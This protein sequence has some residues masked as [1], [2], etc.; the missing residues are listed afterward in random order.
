MKNSILFT[1][2]TI[3][4]AACQKDKSGNTTL[5]APTPQIK[6]YSIGTSDVT[7]SYDTQGRLLTRISVIGN[8][9]YVYT[10]S[11]NSVKEDYYTGAI[12]TGTKNIDLNADGF[13]TKELRTFPATGNYQT[14]YTYTANKQIATIVSSN[15]LNTNTNIQTKFYT[16]TTLDSSHLTYSYNTDK[17]RYIYTYYTDKTNSIGNKNSGRLFYPEDA[18]FPLKQVKYIFSPANIQIDD[19]TYSFDSQNRI[20]KRTITTA[21]SSTPSVNDITYY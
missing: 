15:S 7:Y 3:S 2:I 4:M 14:N 6:T 20:T 9:K 1:L 5:V 8:W 11:T 12:I 18:N 21:G 13:L 17:Y 19:Y 16:G 10:Y